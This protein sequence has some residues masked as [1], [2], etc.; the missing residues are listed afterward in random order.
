MYAKTLIA[1]DGT[2]TGRHALEQALILARSE[3]SRV[4]LVSVVPG[5]EGDLRLMGRM[6]ALEPLREPYR[7]ALKDAEALAAAMGIR[8]DAV[9]A[10]GD[11]VEEILALAEDT[12]ADLLC[13]G[14]RGSYYAD[15]IPIGTVAAKLAR[16]AE[17]DVLLTPARRT[18][19]LAHIV[20]PIDGSALSRAAADRASRLAARYGAALTL[21]TVYEMS[22]EAFAQS[23][24]IIDRF[25]AEAVQ[26]QAPLIAAA[27]GLGV[28]DVAGVVRMGTPVY[29][30]LVDIVC[31]KEAGL[32][33]MGSAGR[34][35]IRRILLGSVAERVI[36]SGEAPVLLVKK[37]LPETREAQ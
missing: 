10:E 6:R 30:V 14:K 32:V 13:A 2:E 9:L 31:E 4:T 15:L 17:C 33:V 29:K 25:H 12:G 18:L 20:A 1:V 7:K 24:D 36:A 5:Y 11:P 21:A 26:R 27:R 22:A 34:G 35:D 19:R 8:A 3:E 28:R 23:P 16:L 37:P